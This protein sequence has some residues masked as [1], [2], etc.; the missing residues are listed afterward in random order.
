MKPVTEPDRV[1]T[2]GQGVAFR[3]SAPHREDSPRVAYSR[4]V[5]VL[6]PGR[7]L[8]DGP[9]ASTVAGRKGRP[10]TN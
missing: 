4:R 2:L 7:V 6:Q 10:M 8:G 9:P 1:L 5:F 3:A